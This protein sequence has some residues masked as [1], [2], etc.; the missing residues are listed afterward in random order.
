MLLVRAPRADMIRPMP[1]DPVVGKGRADERV[2]P[3]AW[4]NLLLLA[5]VGLLM[6]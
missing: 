3:M 6:A 2:P 4:L 5:M 1:K